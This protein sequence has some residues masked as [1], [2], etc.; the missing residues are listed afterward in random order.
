MLKAHVKNRSRLHETG[1]GTNPMSMAPQRNHVVHHS[2]HDR[3]VSRPTERREPRRRSKWFVAEFKRQIKCRAGDGI[4][5]ADGP[6]RV[7]P[8]ELWAERETGCPVRK[9]PEGTGSTS[10]KY[11]GDSPY[12]D[13]P[14]KTEREGKNRGNCS[15]AKSQAYWNNPWDRKGSSSGKREKGEDGY[16]LRKVSTSQP[17]DIVR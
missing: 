6:F 15:R 2:L 9:P 3:V 14:N 17:Q 1:V 4:P 10:Q 12:Q 16:S 5:C 13:A 11:Q 7:C 8:T